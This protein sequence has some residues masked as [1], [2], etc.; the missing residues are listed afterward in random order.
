M[1]LNKECL[2]FI[3]RGLST[4]TLKTAFISCI[5]ENVFQ[6]LNDCYINELLDH[7]LFLNWKLSANS[8]ISVKS[9]NSEINLNYWLVYV[10]FPTKSML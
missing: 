2:F 4:F 10:S 6:E 5:F 8:R 7:N 1:S 9:T 3:G